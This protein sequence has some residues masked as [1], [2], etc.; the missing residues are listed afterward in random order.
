MTKIVTKEN[1]SVDVTFN[2]EAGAIKSMLF[3]VEKMENMA[4]DFVTQ[5]T[6]QGRSQE[7]SEATALYKGKI[8]K[9]ETVPPISVGDDDAMIDW[10]RGQ[11]EYVNCAGR[12]AK[13]K[14]E[15][16]AQRK[17]QKEQ[18]LKQQQQVA[19]ALANFEDVTVVAP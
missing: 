18:L 4:D 1:G 3:I 14:A 2:V 15:Q 13:Q 6:N 19:D 17:A 7:L 9:K 10:Y 16:D 5:A 11:K 8:E 12:V